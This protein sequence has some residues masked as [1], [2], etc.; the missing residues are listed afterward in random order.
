M[1]AASSRPV[2]KKAIFWQSFFFVFVV[3]LAAYVLLQSPLFLIKNIEVRGNSLL[4]AN[5]IARIS[6][7]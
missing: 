3:L 6:G 1:D 2:K 5:E 4:T 7:I